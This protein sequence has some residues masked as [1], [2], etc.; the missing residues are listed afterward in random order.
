MSRCTSCA[1]CMYLRARRRPAVSV[2]QRVRDRERERGTE[3]QRERVQGRRRRSSSSSSIFATRCG[4]S[5]KAA[6]HRRRRAAATAAAA[7]TK[8]A[9]AA[10]SSSAAA[11]VAT[12]RGGGSSGRRSAVA[13]AAAQAATERCAHERL[14][15]LVHDVLLVDLLQDVGADD[16]VQVRL[17]VLE[18][19]VDVAVIVRF[20]HV[21]ELHDVLVVAHLLQEDDLAEGALGVRRVLKRVK[22]L[23]QR[24][25]ILRLL[26][27]R[28]PHDAIRAL[29][30]LLSDLVLPQH[31]LVYLLAHCACRA[32]NTVLRSDRGGR[33][34]RAAP[35][36]RA[37]GRAGVHRRSGCS[38]CS[39]S[40]RRGRRQQQVWL[41][42]PRRWRALSE[43][44]QVAARS[45]QRSS[46]AGTH[47]TAAAEP[48][49]LA[50]PAAKVFG[51][52]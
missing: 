23:L 40:R 36:R 32:S 6:T 28:L 25:H 52:S 41:K 39:R 30:K 9:A 2:H 4:R 10:A 31:V 49:R 11:T 16:R 20:E 14:K 5:S 13:T 18:D 21:L 46:G 26:I 47:L 37:S 1:E 48:L 44:R 34:V 27:V 50:G 51:R 19:Q 45:R 38:C 12:A 3:R 42:R 22:D 17:H 24:H 8:A 15:A 33:A 7:A 35:A 43:P 29:P